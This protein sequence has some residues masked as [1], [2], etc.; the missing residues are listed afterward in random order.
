MPAGVGKHG[1]IS[2]H[3]ID[4]PMR[5]AKYFPPNQQELLGPAVVYLAFGR[6]SKHFTSNQAM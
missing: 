2:Q 6:V 5:I 1:D 3:Q 4:G